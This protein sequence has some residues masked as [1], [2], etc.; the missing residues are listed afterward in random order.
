MRQVRHLPG[1]YPCLSRSAPSDR[2]SAVDDI[3]F[4]VGE[5]VARGVIFDDEPHP[6]ARME[7]HDRWMSFFRDP[8]G[9]PCR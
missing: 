3:A 6:I 1:D 8:M 7:D 9:V 2:S 4:A 5:L